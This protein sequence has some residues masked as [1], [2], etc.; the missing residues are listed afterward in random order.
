MFV[1]KDLNEE[2]CRQLLTFL[3]NWGKFIII[4]SNWGELVHVQFILHIIKNYNVKF[5]VIRCYSAA[6]TLCRW[7]KDIWMDVTILD[8]ATWMIHVTRLT[9]RVFVNKEWN[10]QIVKT[11]IDEDLSILW[12]FEDIKW[13]TEKE[14]KLYEEGDDVFLDTIRLKEL[15][16]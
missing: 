13:L 14:R 1:I 15:L 12:Q 4:N 7:L 3:D 8:W 11:D 16:N 6:Y 5:F 10:I 2:E 9:S